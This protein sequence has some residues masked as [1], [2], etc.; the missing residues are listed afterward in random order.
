[1]RQYL[2]L[3]RHVLENGTAKTDRTGTGTLSLPAGPAIATNC[4]YMLSHA[5]PRSA[6]APWP[7]LYWRLGRLSRHLCTGLSTGV[8]EYFREFCFR[9]AVSSRLNAG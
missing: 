9:T 6:E 8:C 5:P 4:N 1:M 7:A 3:M 2:D